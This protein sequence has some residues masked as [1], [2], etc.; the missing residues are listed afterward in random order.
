MAAEAVHKNM[1]HRPGILLIFTTSTSGTLLK[2]DI[3]A[4]TDRISREGQSENWLF[5]SVVQTYSI[6]GRVDLIFKY[7]NLLFRY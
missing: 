6:L 4:N 3:L 7:L 2:T 5:K 1:P